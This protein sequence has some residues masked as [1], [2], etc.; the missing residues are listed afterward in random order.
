LRW[1]PKT[2]L[3]IVITQMSRA[4]TKKPVSRTRSRSPSAKGREPRFGREA[5]LGA[6]RSAL[7]EDG[8]GGLEVGKLARKLRATRGSFYWFFESRDELM[9]CVITDWEVTNT[10][11]FRSLLR[12]SGANGEAEFQALCDMWVSESGYSPQWDAA[13][14]EWARISPR[15]EAV[16]RRVDDLRITIIQRIFNDMG[17]DEPE[18]FVRART[19]YFH[20]VGYY[21]LGVRE[22]RE[23]RLNLLPIYVRILTGNS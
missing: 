18:A 9:D 23:Q 5:W 20:Q 2:E 6:A 12:D 13:M 3:S 10:A 11:K 17:Y 7:I 8:V 15:V 1:R 16:V 21:T 19:T 14:R 22:S 4:N